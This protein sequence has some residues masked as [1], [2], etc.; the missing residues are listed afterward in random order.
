MQGEALARESVIKKFSAKSYNLS[1][2]DAYLTA[3]GSMA[4][5]A[6]MQLLA[7]KGD[8]FLFPSPGFPLAL[9]IAKSMGL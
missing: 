9:T 6:T 1:K 3:G 5:W 4:I 7:G 2:D 8:N